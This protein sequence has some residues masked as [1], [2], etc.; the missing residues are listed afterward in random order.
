M[1]KVVF[2]F[3]AVFVLK[4]FLSLLSFGVSIVR[5]L[6]VLL[7][8]YKVTLLSFKAFVTARAVS[9]TAE[10]PVIV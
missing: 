4:A 6:I 7:I 10:A 2:E 8:I 5:G 9:V 1:S 3:V